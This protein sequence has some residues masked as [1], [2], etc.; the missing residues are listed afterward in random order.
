[1]RFAASRRSLGPSDSSVLTQE[2]RTHSAAIRAPRVRLLPA[3]QLPP[4][5]VSRSALACR[6][7]GG[8][9]SSAEVRGGEGPR[10][11]RAPSVPCCR[12]LLRAVSCPPDLPAPVQ[13]V[14]ERQ[15]R[16]LCGRRVQLLRRRCTGAPTLPWTRTSASSA[17]RST[18]PTSALPA[19]TSDSEA[20]DASWNGTEPTRTPIRTH[21]CPRASGYMSHA[22][23]PGRTRGACWIGY[24][25]DLR[26]SGI[27]A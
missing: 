25:S 22:S 13:A 12:R 18:D 23:D 6:G 21:R 1:M 11:D 9:R 20:S 15:L 26:P 5:P 3:H 2:Q 16:R 4:L 7:A 17:T 19:S 27:R 24:Q 8:D 10:Q 14:L